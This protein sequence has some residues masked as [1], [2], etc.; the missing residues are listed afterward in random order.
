MQWS[1]SG[2]SE[3]RLESRTGGLLCLGKCAGHSVVSPT[4]TLLAS[5]PLLRWS[6][7]LTWR[8]KTLL[9]QERV[10]LALDLS[11]KDSLRPIMTG[12]MWWN[13][14]PPHCIWE[15]E[16]WGRGGRE[17]TGREGDKEEKETE[18]ERKRHTEMGQKGR[19]GWYNP[20]EHVLRDSWPSVMF[21]L[22]NCHPLSGPSDYDWSV[23]A[24]P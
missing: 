7:L 24:F 18:A 8:Q 12:S 9:N 20:P 1:D 6:S 16:K 22:L 17:R 13:Q 23:P 15:S 21:S 5:F 19:H 14:L 2:K 10:I 11:V 3:V 4:K